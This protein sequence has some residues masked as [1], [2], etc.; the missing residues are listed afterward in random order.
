MSAVICVHT[1]DVSDPNKMKK[2]KAFLKALVLRVD[3]NKKFKQEK[4][5]YIQKKINTK[6]CSWHNK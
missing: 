2:S 3:F 6:Q 4:E 5:F 1:N